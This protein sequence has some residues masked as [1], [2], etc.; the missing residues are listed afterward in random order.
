MN[1]SV[2]IWT[3]TTATVPLHLNAAESQRKRADHHC[4]CHLKHW[5]TTNSAAQVIFGHWAAFYMNCVCCR[6]L[7][8]RLTYAFKTIEKHKNSN[9]KWPNFN[10]SE[11]FLFQS[12]D[13]LIRCALVKDYRPIKSGQHAY[14]DE[15]T[16]LCDSMMDT[17]KQKRATIN[18]IVGHP[19]IVIDY[20][21]SYFELWFVYC[22]ASDWCTW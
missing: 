8:I 4:T 16:S 7:L 10:Y 2:T 22:V 14:S 1:V 17:D 9:N 3:T 5:F 19:L 12:L 18:A 20:Y 11:F 21:H 6:R 15:F 13:E